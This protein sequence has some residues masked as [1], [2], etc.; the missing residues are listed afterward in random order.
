VETILV[1]VPCNPVPEWLEL[2]EFLGIEVETFD[3]D[4]EVLLG[5]WDVTGPVELADLVDAGIVE[6]LDEVIGRDAEDLE[7]GAVFECDAVEFIFSSELEDVVLAGLVVDCVFDETVVVVFLELVG[8]V[9]FWPLDTDAEE[10]FVVCRLDEVVAV[11]LLEPVGN[12]EF[13]PLE[14]EAEEDFVVYRLDEVVAVVFLELVDNVELL[15][16]ETEA[17]EDF[18]VYRLDEIVAGVDFEWVDNVEFSLTEF[19]AWVGFLEKKS[20]R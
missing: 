3:F 7:L 16:L 2:V 10:V 15:P 13:L 12:V 17:E 14:T 19:E 6:F 8:N 20:L 9:E 11:L 4:D 5:L 1:L 18:V